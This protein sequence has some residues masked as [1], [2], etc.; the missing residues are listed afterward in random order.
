MKRCTLRHFTNTDAYHFDINPEQF[1][2]LV[3]FSLEYI[4]GNINSDGLPSYKYNYIDVY[5]PYIGNFSRRE[6][7]AKMPLGRCVNFS[8][9][10][11]FAISRTLNEDA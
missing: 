11:I 4:Q 8:L 1:V 5:I 6:L 9:S 10:P 2:F 7:L 3:T